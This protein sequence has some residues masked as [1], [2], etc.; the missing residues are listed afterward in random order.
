MFNFISIIIE[1]SSLVLL[2]VATPARSSGIT[3][4][5]QV[6]YLLFSFCGLSGVYQN[7][8]ALVKTAVVGYFIKCLVATVGVVMISVLGEGTRL[9]LRLDSTLTDVLVVA[10]LISKCV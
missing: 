6:V 10:G 9:R 2:V 8:A 1:I 7:R 3:Y 4:V 5:M